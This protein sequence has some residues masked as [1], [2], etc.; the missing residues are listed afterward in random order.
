MKNEN[1]PYKARARYKD[2]KYAKNYDFTR[3]QKDTRRQK[4]D[5]STQRA[6]ASALDKLSG[7]R[8]ILDMPCGTGRL[9][10]L[11]QD[12]GYTYFGSDVSREMLTVCLEK[13]PPNSNPYFVCAD[14][15]DMPFSSGTFDCVLCVRFLNLIPPDVRLSILKELFRISKKYLVVSVGYFGPQKRFIEK[16]V[17]KFP[18]LLKKAHARVAEHARRRHELFEAGWRENFW[19]KYKSRGFFSS[20]KTICVYTKDT[21]NK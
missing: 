11:I 7:C 9:L 5:I 16:I 2:L 12:A 15:E 4:R 10:K 21:S 18:W 6:I 19:V 3:Y 13:I 1:T 17:S 8:T 14:G 20:N